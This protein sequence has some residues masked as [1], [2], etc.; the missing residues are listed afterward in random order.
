MGIEIVRNNIVTLSPGPADMHGHPRAFDPVLSDNFIPE[1]GGVEGK[2]GLRA[3]TE[4]ALESGL[5]IMAAMPNEQVRRRALYSPQGTE[6]VAYPIANLDRVIAMQNVINNEAVIPTAIIFGLDPSTCFADKRRTRLDEDYL[7]GQ[8]LQINEECI[9]LKIYGDE[10]TGGNNI[11]PELV[12][13]A[14]EIWHTANPDK[15]VIMHL[16]NDNVGKVLEAV[17]KLKGG[18]DMPIH[19][20]HV[21]S[22]E[23]LEAVIAA[24]KA[25]MNVTCEVTPHHLFLDESARGEIGGYATMKPTLKTRSDV[26][27][28]WANLRYIDIIAS[29]C[30][31]HRTVDKE[32][33]TPQYGVANHAAML[34]LLLG[35]V[36]DGRL[37]MEELYDKLC[38]KP[39]ERFNL[40]QDDGTSVTL[41]ISPGAKWVFPEPRYG[42]DPFQRLQ[43]RFHYAGRLLAAHAGVSELG[44]TVRP[45]YTHLI[46]PK[47]LRE[48]SATNL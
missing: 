42:H 45:S 3:Y 10:S 37:S 22:R 4:V 19:I 7:F 27:F 46:R 13:R 36:V 2:A 23:E 9:A 21:S 1:N 24:K 16:E 5:T 44:G 28:L 8:F 35:A 18:R 32:A 6:L 48:T 33:Q 41:D 12:P 30:A 20:A 39:R 25:G 47:N 17:L 38:V 31:P 34:P 26:D 14:A 43:Q 29:D 40:P 15:P 11:P